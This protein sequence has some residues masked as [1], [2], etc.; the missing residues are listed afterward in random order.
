MRMEINFGATPAYTVGVEEEFQLVDPSSRELVPAID[1]VLAARDAAGLSA[2]SIASELSASC[3]EMR[4]PIYGTVAELGKQ[5]PAL[6]RRIC[7][8]A[9]GCG[10]Q[11]A[12]AGSH[13]FSASKIGRASCRE[14][15]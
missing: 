13:P 1:A 7:D 2:D 12:A 9:E 14:R 15:V 6:R 5:L 11:L 10:T 8:L 3:V 4:S